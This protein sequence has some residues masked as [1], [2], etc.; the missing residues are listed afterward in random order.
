METLRA[1]LRQA[2]IDANSL[3]PLF[4]SAPE[5][6]FE[7]V[8]SR[9][10]A[11][12]TW[13]WLRE[14]TPPIGFWPVLLGDDAS[15][16]HRRDVMNRLRRLVPEKILAEADTIDPVAWFENRYLDELDDIRRRLA[17]PEIAADWIQLGDLLAAEGPL[18]GLPQGPW[19]E[20]ARGELEFRIPLQHRSQFHVGLVPT[21]LGWQTPAY[22][23]FGAWGACPSPGENVALLK[24]WEEHYGAGVV[25]LA[26][27]MMELRVARPPHTEDAALDLAKQHYLYCPDIVTLGTKTVQRLAAS[28]LDST[29]WSF[30]WWH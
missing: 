3:A 18:R 27:D 14:R 26:G 21:R 16:A 23:R 12:T 29:V 10:D 9:S 1:L 11:I 25:G 15:L 4:D 24:Y 7:F 20:G 8:V 17:D 6:G 28:L 30:A 22:L 2:D 5:H 13:H 19:D